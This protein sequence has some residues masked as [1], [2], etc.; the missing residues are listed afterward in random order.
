MITWRYFCA[1]NALWMVVVSWGNM[2]WVRV[3]EVMEVGVWQR[4][5]RQVEGE[6]GEFD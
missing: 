5:F 6:G 1:I 4:L 2:E 3:A